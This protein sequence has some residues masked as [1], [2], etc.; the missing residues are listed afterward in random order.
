MPIF[1]PAQQRMHHANDNDPCPYGP[2]PACVQAPEDGCGRPPGF[3][4]DR[5]D[6][7]E[8]ARLMRALTETMRVIEPGNGRDDGLP[9]GRINFEHGRKRGANRGGALRVT[10]PRR[11]PYIP[12]NSGAHR[13]HISGMAPRNEVRRAARPVFFRSWRPAPCPDLIA[14]NAIDASDGRD[15]DPR[16]RGDGIRVG[17]HPAEWAG[18]DQDAAD[19]WPNV[20]AAGSRSNELHRRQISTL[21]PP[22]SDTAVLDVED[23]SRTMPYTLEVSSPGIEP[24]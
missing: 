13:V 20:P 4:G 14:K 5:P 15:P 22:S 2:L 23:R 24:R 7:G 17:A 9:P 12:F 11:F 8:I 18:Q 3:T 19:R 21:A 6:L 16:D 1:G 10:W